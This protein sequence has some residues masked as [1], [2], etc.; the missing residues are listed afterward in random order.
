MTNRYQITLL[1]NGNDN[2]TTSAGAKVEHGVPQGSI[3]GHLHVLNFIN[4]L[5]TFVRGKSFP[6]LF[7]DHS[8][9]LLPHS[10]PTDFHTIINNVFKILSD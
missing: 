4:D 1:H 3:L 9:I 7:A 10:N 5:D 6:V 2:I 8:R